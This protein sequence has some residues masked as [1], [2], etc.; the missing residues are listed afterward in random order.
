MAKFK[1]DLEKEILD[2]LSKHPNSL[3]KPVHL[4]EQVFFMYYFKVIF[5]IIK[6]NRL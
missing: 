4:F 3:S 6:E 2:Y 1:F 5:L